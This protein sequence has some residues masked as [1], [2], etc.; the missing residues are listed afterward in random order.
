VS[1]PESAVSTRR[2]LLYWR[3]RVIGRSYRRFYA[4]MMDQRIRERP[5][6]GLDLPKRFQLEYLIRQG[7][8]PGSTLLDYGCGAVAA[9]LHMIEYLNPGGYTGVDISEGVLEEALRR[10]RRAGLADRRPTLWH[11]TRGSLHDLPRLP[12]DFVWAQSVLTH[13][14]P[15]DVRELLALLP[16]YLAPKGRVFATITRGQKSVE[17]RNLKDWRYSLTTIA[18]VARDCGFALR[19][20]TDWQHPDDPEGLDTML[21]LSRG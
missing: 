14:P 13:M 9:G 10:V 1:D 21:E 19:I 18:D 15:D 20:C 17:Q 2:L 6:W 4:R 11:L 8:E 7:L 16:A 12:R 5:D 3:H